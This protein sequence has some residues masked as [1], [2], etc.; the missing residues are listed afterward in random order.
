MAPGKSSR[1][2]WY[3]N[4]W[5]AIYLKKALD[6]LQRHLNGYELT[7]EDVY[8]MQQMCAYETVAIGYSKFCE[9]FTEKEWEGFNYSFDLTFW[10]DYSF[11]APVARAQGYGWIEELIAR[12]THTKI[13]DHNPATNATLDDDPITFP[14]NH[15]L[16]VDATHDAVVLTILTALNLT[17]L[18]ASGPLPWTR[19]PR[20]RSFEVSKLVP[21][22]TNVQFQLLQCTSVPGPQIRIIINDGV[23]PLTGI[24]GCLEHPDGLCPV[25]TFVNAQKELL[26]ETDWDWA[27]NG[28]WTVPEGP[29][30]ITT[31]GSPPERPN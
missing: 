16:Y 28:N 2:L 26:A 22:A 17:N 11:G 6:R 3:L 15:P 13:T 10:Y 21:F 30:W 18:A 19:I 5:T 7:I 12:L 25:D 29:E 23:V 1:S 20:H 31:T 4:K 14:L 9:L 27:C 24:K 8:G